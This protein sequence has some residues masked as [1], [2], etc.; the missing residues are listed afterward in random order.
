MV[1]LCVSIVSIQTDQ[2]RQKMRQRYIN[3]CL[4]F[5]SYQSK[6]INPDMTIEEG[7]IFIQKRVSIVSIQTDQSRL[8]GGRLLT[9]LICSFNR[10][11]PNRS[12]P[13]VQMFNSSHRISRGFNR[14]NPNR[15]IPTNKRIECTWTRSHSFNRINPNRSIPT[16]T[17]KLGYA[18]AFGF[19]SY[20][21][22][23]IN[24]DQE[25]YSVCKDS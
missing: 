23:Q 19:Q 14:I 4:V 3:K 9:V 12:I 10:I 2:S 17:E 11:N 24:P 18:H 13:T 20:Q 6:Q 7:V 22:K 16:K 21:S 8:I 5:Q 25:Y 15:S 1:E